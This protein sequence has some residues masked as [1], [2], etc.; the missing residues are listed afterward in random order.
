MEDTGRGTIGE[1]WRG[2]GKNR[3]KRCGMTIDKERGEGKWR[4]Q[5]GAGRKV[6]NKVQEETWVQKEGVR[7]EEKYG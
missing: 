4:H 6:G 7:R 3:W 5:P 2:Q 1:R